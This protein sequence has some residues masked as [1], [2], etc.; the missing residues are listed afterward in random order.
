MAEID[1]IPEDYRQALQIRRWLKTFAAAYGLGVLCIVLA[2][3]LLSFSIGAEASEIERLKANKT[4]VLNQ[5]AQLDALQAEESVLEKRLAVLNKLRGGPPVRQVFLDI[6]R[7]V[8]GKV[9]F[10]DWE[11]MRAGEFVQVKPRTVQRGYFIV[12]PAEEQGATQDR[13]WQMQTHMRIKAQAT[14][15]SSLADFV[16]RL[17]Q[18]SIIEDIKVLNTRLRSYASTQVVDFELAVIV[19]A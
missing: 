15:H 13:A 3:T 7:A 1:L 12:V 4:A 2:K 19:R 9:W 11:F 17:G 18:Q 14:D 5:R 6:D 10:L 8:D 16:R